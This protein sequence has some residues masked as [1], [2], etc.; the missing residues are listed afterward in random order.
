MEKAKKKKK[1]KKKKYRKMFV[2]IVTIYY[3]EHTIEYD[4]Y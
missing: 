2:E 1:K 4:D 3:I